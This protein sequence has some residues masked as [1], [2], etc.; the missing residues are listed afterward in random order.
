M[1]IIYINIK[2]ETLTRSLDNDCNDEA[3]DAQDTSHDYGDDVLHDDAGVHHTH[4]GDADAGLGGSVRGADV[5][6]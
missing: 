4:G 5:C 2:A 1:Q 3:V 6:N